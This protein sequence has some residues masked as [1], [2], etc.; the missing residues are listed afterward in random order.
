M[1]LLHSLAS[2]PSGGGTFRSLCRAAGPARSSNRPFTNGCDDSRKLMR[3]ARGALHLDRLW[4]RLPG[5]IR[6]RRTDRR[7]AGCCARLV[8]RRSPDIGA[9][10]RMV[11]RG[12][13]AGCQTPLKGRCRRTCGT[14]AR[15]ERRFSPNW[16]SSRP[17]APSGVG[18]RKTLI[19]PNHD[20]TPGSSFRALTRA[21]IGA[22]SR[23]YHSVL[24]QAIR[25]ALQ[26]PQDSPPL[27]MR[28]DG[29]TPGQ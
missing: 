10:V 28:G 22:E 1:I 2:S 13:L 4:H 6:H 11:L 23:L 27:R 29:R 19:L 3:H 26:E 17:T 16:R 14:Q 15:S 20:S 9:G 18:R 7:L 8:R 21:P 25:E 5:G 24:Y 12:R